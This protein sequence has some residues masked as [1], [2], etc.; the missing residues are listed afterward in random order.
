MSLILQLASDCSRRL[1]DGLE[2]GQDVWNST[3][4]YLLVLAQH[5]PDAELKGAPGTGKTTARAIYYLVTGRLPKGQTPADLA[6]RRAV[7]SYARFFEQKKASPPD[8]REVLALCERW[9][10]GR[11]MQIAETA[12]RRRDAV[13]ALVTGPA[14]LFTERCDCRKPGAAAGHCNVCFGCGWRFATQAEINAKTEGGHD[15]TR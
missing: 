13:G 7:E 3:Y 6:E 15:A 8:E 1:Y 12:W 2:P 10:Y 9:G 14:A 5:G 4:D 11:V